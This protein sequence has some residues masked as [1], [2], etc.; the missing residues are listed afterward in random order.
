MKTLLLGIGN[1]IRGDDVIGI[2]LVRELCKE[3]FQN[4]EIRELETAGFEVLDEMAGFDKVI[5]LD[6]M[7]TEKEE[8]VGKTVVCTLD[9]GRPTVTLLPSHGFDFASLINAYRHAMP[10]KFPRDIF[11]VLVKVTD[12]DTF[13][14]GLGKKLEEN[15]FTILE[16][17][18]EHIRNILG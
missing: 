11:F 18:K 3:N 8:N 10:K 15:F 4:V 16:E 14:E 2:L 9:E 6:A 12:V 7:R 17:V 5:I 13:R 1:T